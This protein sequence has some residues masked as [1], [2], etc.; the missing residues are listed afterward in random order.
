MRVRLLGRRL[1]VAK[2]PVLLPRG[3]IGR[4]IR[5]HVGEL[6]RADLCAWVHM[7]ACWQ[8]DSSGPCRAVY[9]SVYMYMY[10]YMTRVDH[11]VQCGEEPAWVRAKCEGEGEGE[12]E[13]EGEGEGEV[14][15]SWSGPC[16]AAF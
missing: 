7:H 6:A 1:R 15:V 2:P 9:V 5:G 10:V 14:R 8:A 16:C 12:C 13:G 3:A 4:Q 11:A